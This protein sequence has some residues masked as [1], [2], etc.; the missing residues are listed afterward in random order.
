MIQPIKVKNITLGE[1]A[2]KIC[3][4]IVSETQKELLDEVSALHHLPIDLI[5]WRADFYEDVFQT[6]KVLSTLKL[7]HESAPSIPLIFTFRTKAEGGE[8]SISTDDYFSLALNVAKSGL[9]DFIDIEYFLLQDTKQL[10]SYI[11]QLQKN[12]TKVILSNHDFHKTPAKE[13]IIERLRHMQDLNC[14]IPKIAVMPASPY[15]VLTLLDATYTFYEQYSTKPVITMSMTSMGCISRIS[16]EIF[17][18][19]ITFGSASQASA[20]GQIPVT[21]LKEILPLF[22]Q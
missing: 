19:C 9:A 15:D 7:L 1:G 21:Q 11:K 5:E 10:Q 17:G 16:G 13:E 22:T 4:P 12:G 20:P 18:S 8:K 14:D 6:D 3:A 2:P